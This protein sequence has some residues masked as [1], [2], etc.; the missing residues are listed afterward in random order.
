MVLSWSTN[1]LRG[2]GIALCLGAGA[3]ESVSTTTTRQATTAP[4]SGDDRVRAVDELIPIV[5]GME[6]KHQLTDLRGKVFLLADYACGTV[7]EVVDDML[8]NPETTIQ[9]RVW[10][11]QL[12]LDVGRSMIAT[13][14][15]PDPVTDLFQQLFL[16]RVA[17][18]IVEREAPKVMGARAEPLVRVFQHL[19][20]AAWDGTSTAIGRPL[21]ALNDDVE[22][23]LERN[24]DADR[25]W[26]AREMG[27]L[28]ALGSKDLVTYSGL[29]AAVDRAN[30]GI[31]RLNMT[32]VRTSFVME[33]LP[34]LASWEFQAAAANLMARPDVQEFSGGPSALAKSITTLDNSIAKRFAAVGDRLEA[35]REELSVTSN[36]LHETS[37]TLGGGLSGTSDALKNA[38]TELQT[39]LQTETQLLSS[40]VTQSSNVIDVGSDDVAKSLDTLARTID[41][42]ANRILDRVDLMEDGFRTEGRAVINGVAWRVG[43]GAGI[44]IILTVVLSVMGAWWVNR[45]AAGHPPRA[46]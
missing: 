10:L 37:E 14:S 40:S 15:N 1:T 29:F 18:V 35:V 27:L 45:L 33:R 46:Q 4:T 24:P 5:R 2:L 28:Q 30:Q 42:E 11:Q 36:Q 43:I 39:A 44:L 13:A 9:Q 22:L 25:F 3:C 38:V 20:K 26:W 6:A 7:G 31:D 17:R 8:I 32:F 21:T 23:W 34:M 16:I 12:R 19:D 41:G